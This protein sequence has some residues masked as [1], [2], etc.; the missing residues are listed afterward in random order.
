[1]EALIVGLRLDR[2][3]SGFKSIVQIGG[4]KVSRLS[5][6]LVECG[7]KDNLWND[8][9]TVGRKPEEKATMCRLQLN[10]IATIGE[11][12]KESST[13][14]THSSEDSCRPVIGAKP[15]GGC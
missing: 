1:M 9:V 15:V 7:Q 8:H 11:A 5:Q 4:E 2:V 3:G 6:L 14:S 12:T 13:H 10:S